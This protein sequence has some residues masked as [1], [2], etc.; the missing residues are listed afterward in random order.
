[1]PD[2]TIS[3]AAKQFGLRTSALRYYEQIGVIPPAHRSGGQRRYDASALRRLAIVQRAR[4]LGF[5][6]KEIQVLF[7]NFT[8]GPPISKRWHDLSQA[9]LAELDEQ[10]AHIHV[11]Q[12]MLRKMMRCRCRAFDECGEGILQAQCSRQSTS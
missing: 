6:L 9:K 4:Q 5:S 3:K 12:D 11:M 8:S 1:M 7:A 2:L 10:I